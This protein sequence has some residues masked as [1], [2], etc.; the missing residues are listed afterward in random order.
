MID[1][2]EYIVKDGEFMDE[3]IRCKDCK[4]FEEDISYCNELGIT[5]YKD[6]Y[7]SYADW[8]EDE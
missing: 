1:C 5:I 6:D 7:C 2:K 4:F 3:L 8:R